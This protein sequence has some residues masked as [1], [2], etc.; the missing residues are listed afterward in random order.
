MTAQSDINP[1]P[2]MSLDELG[3][4]LYAVRSSLK[5]MKAAADKM[6]RLRLA[7]ELAIMLETMEQAIE[8]FEDEKL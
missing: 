8:V 4:N 1:P 3:S 5:S 6:H 2:A 7:L